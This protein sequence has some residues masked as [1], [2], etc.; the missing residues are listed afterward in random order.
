ME[1]ECVKSYDHVERSGMQKSRSAS[2][3]NVCSLAG[4]ILVYVLLIDW[5]FKGLNTA[6][7]YSMIIRQHNT[8]ITSRL[9]AR[10]L[11]TRFHD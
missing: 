11:R 5:L 3:L 8:E 6:S 4:L 2:L 1:T 10:L 7:V 9:R